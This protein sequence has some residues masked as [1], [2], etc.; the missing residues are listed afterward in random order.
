MRLYYA[1]RCITS[2]MHYN[3]FYNALYIKAL[4]KVLLK[5]F[6]KDIY[7]LTLKNIFIY[8]FVYSEASTEKKILPILTLNQITSDWFSF[9]TFSLFVLSALH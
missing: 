2:V 3:Y 9:I 1:L 6:T 7:F 5:E 8:L 4:S